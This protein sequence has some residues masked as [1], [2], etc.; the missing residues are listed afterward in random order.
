MTRKAHGQFS[1][2]RVQCDCDSWEAFSNK[3]GKVLYNLCKVSSGFSLQ[4]YRNNKKFNV[5]TVHTLREIP[6]CIGYVYPEIYL[7]KCF[8]KLRAQRIIELF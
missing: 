5:R 8:V 7:I 2:L 1:I 3:L 4:Y 6:Q